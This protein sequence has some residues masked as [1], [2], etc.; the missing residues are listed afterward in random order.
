MTIS[1][2]QASELKPGDVLASGKAILAVGRAVRFSGSRVVEI[3]YIGNFG[4]PVTG[5]LETYDGVE[6]Q[7]R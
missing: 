5:W 2:K 7:S 6:V 3:T 4:E 1:V